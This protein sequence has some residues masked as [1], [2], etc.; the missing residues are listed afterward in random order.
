MASSRNLVNPLP[1]PALLSFSQLTAGA[2]VGFLLSG[3]LGRK[4]QRITALALFAAG[5]AAAVPAIVDKI[6]TDRH[7]STSERGLRRRLD[8]IRGGNSFPEDTDAY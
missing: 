3:R 6:V 4:A 2:G 5:A 1:I 7:N 8:R